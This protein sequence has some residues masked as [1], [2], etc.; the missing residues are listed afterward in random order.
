MYSRPSPLTPPAT[1][2]ARPPSVLLPD[3]IGKRGYQPPAVPD[4]A[5]AVETL[6]TVGSTRLCLGWS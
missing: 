2:M 4:V 1:Q 5:S 3:L 6:G